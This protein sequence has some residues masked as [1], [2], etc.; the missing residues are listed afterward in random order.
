MIEEFGVPRWAKLLARMTDR[1]L[2]RSTKRPGRAD[3]IAAADGPVN[4]PVATSAAGVVD[5]A[6][7]SRLSVDPWVGGLSALIEGGIVD[8]GS[9]AGPP[10]PA[11]FPGVTTTWTA[12]GATDVGR[13][14]PAAGPSGLVAATVAAEHLSAP[15]AGDPWDTRRIATADTGAVP[16][17]ATPPGDR[18]AFTT[19]VADESEERPGPGGTASS[20]GSSD[21]TEPAEEV[22]PNETAAAPAVPLDELDALTPNL[23]DDDA[24]IPAVP[25]AVALAGFTAAGATVA[26]TAVTATMSVAGAA[27]GGSM[28]L[29][30]ISIPVGSTP[31]TLLPNAPPMDQSTPEPAP[32]FVDLDLPAAAARVASTPDERLAVRVA[33]DPAG[34][35]ESE[36]PA[37]E[38]PAADPV[39][40]GSVVGGTVE[41]DA[42]GERQVAGG[43]EQPSEPGISYSSVPPMTGSLEAAVPP[44]PAADVGENG[45]G[46]ATPAVGASS[47]GDDVAAASAEGAVIIP[48]AVPIAVVP[49]EPEAIGSGPVQH[50]PLGPV[51]D[52]EAT[53]VAAESEVPAAEPA[54][55]M[56]P[57]APPVAESPPPAAVPDKA[58]TAAAALRRNA[59]SVLAPAV[60][61]EYN[62]T[63]LDYRRPMPRPK[64][65]GRVI[66]FHC[67]L[68]MRRHADA[69]FEAADHYGMY[70][71]LTMSPLEE[72]VGLARDWGHRVKF[73]AMP[74]WADASPRWADNWRDRIAAF[75]N[76]GSRIAKFHASPGTML[77]RGHRLDAPVFRPL[78][79]D[80]RDRG[81]AIMTHIGDPDTWYNGRYTDT[82]KFGSRDDHHRMWEDL[83]ERYRGTTWIGAH[84]G[85]N[86]EDLP[87][88]QRLLDRFPDLMLD[89]SAT[90]W[91]VREISARRDAARE[92]FIRNQDRILFGSDQVSGDDR[93]F[94]FLASR[95][96]CHRKLWETAYQG[97]SPIIDPDVPPDQQPVLRGLALPD[98]VL[99]KLYHDNATKLLGRL[100]M[101]FDE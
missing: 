11:E 5:G 31:L 30:A 58:A 75:Y 36:P 63:N 86:P 3:V 2:R 35:S 33:A 93:G 68:F 13:P 85:G 59:A 7:P 73:I 91:M 47:A 24:G 22:S 37:G 87:R 83:L 28:A 17:A 54:V 9:R 46:E 25:T 57:A 76:L 23:A 26:A 70:G 98:A 100:G 43:V 66:D 69:W 8:A 101:G 4:V 94:D 97:P 41:D 84:M 56:P 78:L 12:T 62:R 21:P 6:A 88:L 38:R 81:M 32:A 18:S 61:D 14:P 42:A 16:A 45:G 44:S 99:Q 55:D 52:P 29:A 40:E 39:A 50:A 48:L 82:A 51:P 67:H 72:C 80:V 77:M 64:V 71:F 49:P 15:I 95:I 90:R 60:R 92:F 10:E 79:D 96:W 89:C 1:H 27:A 20:A 34:E 65:R 53:G 19:V 74:Q